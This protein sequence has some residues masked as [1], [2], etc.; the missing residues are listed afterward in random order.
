MFTYQ[1]LNFEKLPQKWPL[2]TSI[3]LRRE[4]NAASTNTKSLSCKAGT[5]KV[6]IWVAH[7]RNMG[8]RKSQNESRKN[9]SRKS[10]NELQ[11]ESHNRNKFFS[12]QT[13][14]FSQTSSKYFSSVKNSQ[15]ILGRIEQK[16]SS[17]GRVSRNI[18]WETS[19]LFM[20]SCLNHFVC[21]KTQ[22]IVFE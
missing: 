11:S 13:C 16:I 22:H 8:S 21:A 19:T 6:A 17:L 20:Q 2:N 4:N 18:N 7:N 14:F 12:V 9:E 15:N 3:F 10:Q 1:Y 5:K